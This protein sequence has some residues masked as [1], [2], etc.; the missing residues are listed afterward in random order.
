MR[1]TSTLIWLLGALFLIQSCA[2]DVLTNSSAELEDFEFKVPAGFPDM[3]FEEEN[4]YSLDKWK[5]GKA[6]FYENAFSIDGKKS[7][8]SCHKQTLGFADNVAFS[9]GANEAAGTR[10][11][12]T[13]TNVGYQPYFMK[14]GG[15]RTLELQ[16]LVPIQEHNEFNNNILTISDSLKK[17]PFYNELSLKAYNR[18]FD[19]Y[20]LTR[21]LG[22]FE[23]TL[24]SGNSPYDQW[25]YQGMSEALNAKELEGKDLFFGKAN[26][27]QCHSD[28]NF[29]NYAF[30]NNGLY[31]NYADS[32]RYRLTR[33]PEDWGKFKV[34]TLRNIE[35]TAPYMHDGSLASLDQVL[36]HYNSGGANNPLKS[37]L[38]KPLGL[39][40]QELDALEAFLHTLTDK[41]FLNNR[42]FEQD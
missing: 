29:S 13:L 24:V 42:H 39:T 18:P 3:E 20:V 30:E 8:A 12:P 4:P 9:P 34:P 25:A 11:A 26:C 37:S 36:E 5:L 38:I 14:E 6:L 19:Y 10:N 35:V 40:P 17:I 31:E 41:E 21:A 33:A 28:F 15:V 16:A 32:G 27:S 22:I 7:C 2:K 23:R 1:K